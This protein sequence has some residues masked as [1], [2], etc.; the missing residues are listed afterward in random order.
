MRLKHH[1]VCSKGKEK[2]TV[3]VSRAWWGGCTITQNE[4][5]SD[6]HFVK[7]FSWVLH[8]GWEGL[9]RKETTEFGHLGRPGALGTE[10]KGL[11]LGQGRWT[12]RVS[13]ST[14]TLEHL[15]PTLGMGLCS[16]QHGCRDFDSDGL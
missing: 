8:G 12:C 6:S 3:K 11:V 2:P 7:L 1:A 5:R 4:L 10:R 9:W 16:T 13:Q 15:G 14:F